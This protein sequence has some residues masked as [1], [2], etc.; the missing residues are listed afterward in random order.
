MIKAVLSLLFS[1]VLVATTFAQQTTSSAPSG[2]REES[3]EIRREIRRENIQDMR[4]NARERRAE[5]KTQMQEKREEFKK[6]IEAKREELKNEI[7]ARKEALKIRLKAIKDERKKLAVERIDDGLG[8]MNARMTAHFTDVLD[9]LAD[10]LGRIVSRTDKAADGGLDVSAVRTAVT[11]AESAIASARSAVAAQAGKAY[12]ITVTTEDTLR[13]DVGGA[14][15]ALHDDLKKV[16]DA[17]KAAREKVRKAATTLA[18]IPG[19]DQPAPTS[20][21]AG[22]STVQ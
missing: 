11:E 10:V 18:Q 22:T 8:K 4:Q 14:R 1:F 3:R 17:V 19:V 12:S 2:V 6:T 5:L 15:K 21:S 13:A 20:T 7:E 9:K 16:Q